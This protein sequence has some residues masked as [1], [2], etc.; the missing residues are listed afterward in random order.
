MNEKETLRN[1]IFTLIEKN[2]FTSIDQ[3]LPFYIFII[4]EEGNEFIPIQYKECQEEDPAT[5]YD[6]CKKFWADQVELGKMMNDVI[7]SKCSC[8]F[9][10]L[11]IP[12]RINEKFVG[13]IGG[14]I[15]KKVIHERAVE[16][17]IALF[18]GVSNII[19]LLGNKDYYS[20]QM[21]THLSSFITDINRGYNIN[22]PNSIFISPVRTVQNIL[23]EFSHAIEH[24]ACYIFLATDEQNKFLLISRDKADTLFTDGVD[25]FVE[26]MKPGDKLMADNPLFNIINLDGRVYPI[27]N[28]SETKNIGYLFLEESIHLSRIEIIEEY[29]EIILLL[30]SSAYGNSMMF[31]NIAR[32]GKSIYDLLVVNFYKLQQMLFQHDNTMSGTADHGIGN[33]NKYGDV[34]IKENA[35]TRDDVFRNFNFPGKIRYLRRHELLENK[36]EKV[37]ETIYVKRASPMSEDEKIELKTAVVRHQMYKRLIT[38][39]YSFVFT[40]VK[41]NEIKD[42]FKAGKVHEIIEMAEAVA[43]SMKI[44]REDIEKIRFAAYLMDVGMIGISDSILDSEKKLT[45]EEYEKIRRHPQISHS[46]LGNFP[47]FNEIV[48]I[49]EGHHEK[50]DGSGYPAGLKGTGIPVGARILNAVETYISLKHNRKFREALSDEEIYTI[51]EKE[52]EKSFD[53]DITDII[54]GMIKK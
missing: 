42:P 37:G 28:S 23:G 34:F 14:C 44:K 52:K 47:F 20:T 39:Y 12:I 40:L 30:F 29:V 49:L 46:L 53:P 11:Q 16:K 13:I 26:N 10:T 2:I 9:N 51:M 7:C 4:D 50:W 18:K 5:T 45:P 31:T 6:K 17:T 36:Y 24:A 32:A 35:D 1:I 19:E 43:H 27:K 33:I 54:L 25:Y 22:D 48:D 41:G 8:G 21:I 3:G 38:I 15:P